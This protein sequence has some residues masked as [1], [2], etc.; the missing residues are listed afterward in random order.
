MADRKRSLWSVLV[1]DIPR[2]VVAASHLH[3]A[4]LIVA[5]LVDHEDL[6][7]TGLLLVKCPSSL[8]ARIRRRARALGVSER[9][10]ACFG[11]KMFLTWIGALAEQRDAV[12][13]LRMLD[14]ESQL[15]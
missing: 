9:F 10:L 8:A 6:P 7:P 15:S 2:A 13:P 4:R 5:A 12:R 1:D 14:L 11:E 3:E